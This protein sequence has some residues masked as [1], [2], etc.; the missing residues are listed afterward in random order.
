MGEALASAPEK[1]VG[2]VAEEGLLQPPGGDGQQVPVTQCLH[3]LLPGTV[4]HAEHLQE[5]PKP[6]RGGVQC[7]KL[8][9]AQLSEACDF[10]HSITRG[11]HSGE[12]LTGR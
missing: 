12:V 2:L 9:G 8:S 1:G 6:C 4:E 11:P 3:T 7:K 5:Q 10:S